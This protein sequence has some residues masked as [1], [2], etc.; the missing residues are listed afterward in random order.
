M[1]VIDDIENDESI[2]FDFFNAIIISLLL[3]R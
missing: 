2:L 3:V 1:S